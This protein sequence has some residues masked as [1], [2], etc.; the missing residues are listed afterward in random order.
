[1]VPP[2]ALLQN[3]LENVGQALDGQDQSMEMAGVRHMPD[4][5]QRA[6]D[7][8]MSQAAAPAVAQQQLLPQAKP[9]QQQQ[10]EQ[11]VGTACWLLF[12]VT[13]PTATSMEAL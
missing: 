7:G 3:K 1:M 9:A 13:C 6:L 8:F 4:K 5:G 11:Q 10:Q 2:T 12:I